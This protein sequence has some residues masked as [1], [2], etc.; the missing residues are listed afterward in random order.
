M[1]ARRVAATLSALAV[2]LA[3]PLVRAAQDPPPAVRSTEG[4]VIA[5]DAGDLVVDLGT[6]SGVRAGQTVEL[7]RPM[8]L[9]HPVTGKVLV[10]RFRIGSVRLAEVE[11]VLSLARGDTS[12][13]QRPPA[14][15]DIVVVPSVPPPP[16][17][18]PTGPSPT[19]TRAAGAT[20]TFVSA[21]PEAKALSDLFSNLEGTTPARRAA[22]YTAFLDAHPQSRFTKVL[23]EEIEALSRPTATPAQFQSSFV[24]IERLKPGAAQ[25]YAIELDTRFVG[26]VIHVRQRGASGYRSIPMAAVGPRY[27]TATLPGDAID[28]KGVE[29]FVEGVPKAGAPVAVIGSANAPEETAVDARPTTGKQAGTLAQLSLSSEIASFNVKR[30]ND[31]VFQTEGAF[32]WRM[33]DTGVRA[34]RSGFGV[35]RGKGGSLVDLD[36]LGVPARDVGLTYGWIETELAPS[37]TFSLIARPIIG[38]REGGATG[39]AQGFFR[40]GNDLQTNLMIGGEVLGT[41]GLRGVVQLEWK[42]IPRVP[43]LV[44][45][46]VTNQPAGVGGDIGAR[47]IAQVGYEVV[48]D[49][50]IAIRGSYQ[51]RTINHAGPGAG[52]GV[53]YQ[54]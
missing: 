2:T 27:W 48:R 49:L 7:W 28:P 21:D 29:Y 26:A 45:S 13:F 5:I 8:K 15:G 11:N 51:G 24:P 25:H 35:L 53:S 40:I 46:E 1:P 20:V 14:T 31:Y 36:Q 4:T 12:T 43:I 22:A 38:L 33:K 32:G 10:D 16:A 47:A 50:S 3:A 52:A 44:R 9:R 19:T 37:R 39:G 34:V 18:E 42:T 17:K 41:V 6:A 30:A 54:W 23:R